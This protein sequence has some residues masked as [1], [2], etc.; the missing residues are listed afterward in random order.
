MRELTISKEREVFIVDDVTVPG[1]PPVGR[2]RTVNE[3]LGEYLRN[4]QDRLGI[5]LVVHDSAMPTEMRRRKRL[6]KNR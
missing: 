5:K 1:S 6:L 4:N 2:G 3:A